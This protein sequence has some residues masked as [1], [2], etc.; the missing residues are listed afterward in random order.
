MARLFGLRAHRGFRKIAPTIARD[1]DER[2]RTADEVMFGPVLV[3]WPY[4]EVA[5]AIDYINQR[6][7]PLV[8]TGTG[9]TTTTSAVSSVVPEAVV[10]PVMT[11]PHK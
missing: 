1:V 6:P 10:W 9:Q 7:A 5:D 3:V 11:L 8:A 2:M 4:S